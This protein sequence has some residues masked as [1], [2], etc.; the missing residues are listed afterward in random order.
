MRIAAVEET[1]DAPVGDGEDPTAKAMG[2]KGG[3]ARAKSLAAQR[4]QEMAKRGA[5]KRRSKF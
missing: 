2:E 5:A 4:R 1:E 3:A